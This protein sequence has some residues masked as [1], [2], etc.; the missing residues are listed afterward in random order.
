MKPI[1]T[2]YDNLKVARDAPPEVIRAAYKTLCK[3]FHPDHHQNKSAMT[4]TFQLISVAYNVLSDPVLRQQHDAWIAK[5]EAKLI[6]EVIP[7][8]NYQ[9]KNQRAHQ[10]RRSGDRRQSGAVLLPDNIFTELLRWLP[11]SRDVTFWVSFI[12]IAGL[13]VLFFRAP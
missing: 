8:K 10:V 13:L 1:H 5:T 3:K 6:E 11:N 7:Q 2:H 9:Q 12:F 4:K